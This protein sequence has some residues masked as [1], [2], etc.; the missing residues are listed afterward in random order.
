MRYDVESQYIFW[1]PAIFFLDS[2]RPARAVHIARA[3]QST[4]YKTSAARSLS[5]LEVEA[6]KMSQKSA[7]TAVDGH[8]AKSSKTKGHGRQQA[9]SA[10]PL[11][12]EELRRQQ[13]ITPEDVLRLEKATKGKASRPWA[14]RDHL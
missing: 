6:G 7:T 1:D 10:G 9:K 5:V 3:F 4:Q 12:E 2:Q 13:Y 8:T 11:S 14:C